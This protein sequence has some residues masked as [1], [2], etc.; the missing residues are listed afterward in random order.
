MKDVEKA[1]A[2]MVDKLIW[3]REGKLLKCGWWIG[4]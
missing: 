2:D 1:I 4:V 3:C